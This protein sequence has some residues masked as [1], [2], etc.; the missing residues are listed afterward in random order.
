M[1]IPRSLWIEIRGTYYRVEPTADETGW[2]LAKDRARCKPDEDGVY[3]VV[4]HDDGTV[5][6]DCP[7]YTYRKANT[8][9]VCKHG[10]ALIDCGFLECPWITPR[11]HEE[12]AK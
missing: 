10:Q 12:H 8:P 9:K 11:Q 5:E 6:C 1:V 4:R 7:D 3:H 2:Q